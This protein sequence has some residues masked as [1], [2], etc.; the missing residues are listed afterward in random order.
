MTVERKR[1]LVFIDWFLPGYRAGGP[2]RSLANVVDHLRSQFDFFIIT[3][4]T[5]YQSDEPYA[6]MPA[7][8]WVEFKP[9]VNVF[10]LSAENQNIKYIS[11]L[12]SNE[13]FDLG[14]VNG[15]YS[16]YF[17]I[18]P[19]WLM[20]RMHKPVVISAR[21]MLSVHAFSRKAVKKRLFISLARVMAFYS[22]ACFHAT[23]EKEKQEILR[24]FPSAKV[25]V[26]PNP[27]RR[28]DYL[29]YKP[30]S[31]EAGKLRLVSIARISQEKNT[32]FALQV[33]SKIR[34]GKVE[35]DLYGS[36]YDQDYWQQCQLVINQMPKN[37]KVNFRGPIHT[38]QVIDTFSQYHFSFMPS[39]GE[40]F[41]HSIFESFAA[42]TPVIISSNTPWKGLKDSCLGW[43]IDLDNPDDFV[44][45][46]E[47]CISMDG[48]EYER[49]SRKVFD[50][51]Q[52]Y[53]AQDKSRDLYQALFN[54][55]CQ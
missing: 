32:L 16:F 34:Q 8:K 42:G 52:A 50:F 10:Y 37:V 14:Y 54:E 49:M 21:G 20:R 3:R 5:D 41:G 19:V 12:V 35:F 4:N 1:I 51:A 48:D 40:N 17:S 24:F 46:I 31:K 30:R 43:G 25:H 55:C 15:I 6:D 45:T 9:G 18:L 29:D 39:L 26:I 53:A 13:D 22:A 27:V 44:Q 33:L 7:N 11:D 47:Q 2:I 38:E 23:S 36:V 28:V